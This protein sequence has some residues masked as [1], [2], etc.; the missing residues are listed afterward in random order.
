MSTVQKENLEL[1]GSQGFTLSATLDRPG[2]AGERPKAYAL[3]AHCFTCTKD[4]LAPARVG[5]ALAERGVAVLRFDFTGLGQ[6]CGEFAETGF[7]TNVAD[8]EAAAEF[9]RERFEA[10]RLLIGHSLGGAAVMAAA[11]R[12]PEVR[13]VASI[14]APSRS[15]GLRALLEPVAAAIRAE[16]SAEVTVAGRSVLVGRRLLDDLTEL[17]PE[18][19]V[20]DLRA[21]L[22]LLHSPADETVD[23]RAAGELFA[24]ARHPKSF[25]SLGDADHLL[26][27]REDALYVAAVVDAWASRYLAG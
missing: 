13:A 8:V 12:I 1:L 21:A 25:V 4:F 26:S 20:E 16:G 3:F 10:P 18:G 7:T 19:I 24:A 14:A 5:K 15:S 2:D 9:L 23:V 27:R 6:S 17:G 11:S 22:L